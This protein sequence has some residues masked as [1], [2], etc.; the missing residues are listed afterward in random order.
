[1]QLFNLNEDPGETTNIASAHPERVA[2]LGR[3]MKEVYRP[4]VRE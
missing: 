3:A 4:P 1:V 2:G